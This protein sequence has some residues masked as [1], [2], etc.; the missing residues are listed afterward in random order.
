MTSPEAITRGDA[1]AKPTRRSP[2]D[3]SKNQLHKSTECL[4]DSRGGFVQSGEKLGRIHERNTGIAPKS[5]RKKQGAAASKPPCDR[6]GGLE[7]AAPWLPSF[8]A[9]IKTSI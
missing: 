8:A 5:F 3:V 2:G 4:G 6:N 7:T 9:T 1:S